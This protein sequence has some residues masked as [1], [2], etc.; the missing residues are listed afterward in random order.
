MNKK[1]KMCGLDP[2]IAK[3][4]D[5]IQDLP[6]ISL[7][8]PKKINKKAKKILTEVF[9]INRPKLESEL[10]KK[11]GEKMFFEGI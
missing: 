2:D 8:L 10:L 4:L 11:I 3:V 1:Y 5:M 7:K 9:E 6:L